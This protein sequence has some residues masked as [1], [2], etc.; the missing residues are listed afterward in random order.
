MTA[1]A[2]SPATE[3]L[4]LLSPTPGAP[5][6]ALAALVPEAAPALAPGIS[7]AAPAPGSPEL[8]PSPTFSPSV[9]SPSP[10]EPVPSRGIPGPL[11][12][13][14]SPVAAPSPS[15]LPRSGGYPGTVAVS[16]SASFFRLSPEAVPAPAPM[17]HNLPSP[18][19]LEPAVPPFQASSPGSYPAAAPGPAP[20][21]SPAPT[22][23]PDVCVVAGDGSQ[24]AGLY[25][26]V[27]NSGSA[28][29]LFRVDGVTYS[30]ETQPWIL[31][32]PSSGSV[33]P[34]KLIGLSVQLQQFEKKCSFVFV[35][36][37]QAVLNSI[38]ST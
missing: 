9:P 28:D 21:T 35:F 33:L 5:E 11:P 38:L 8:V 12:S 31:T 3:E 29:L 23:L 20:G 13:W 4:P 10:G 27:V 26:P 34:G 37:G 6:L 2:P 14:G 1:P 24:P 32:S 30:K 19:L 7:A 17:T 16:P 22:P 15:L 36:V 25:M 18:T